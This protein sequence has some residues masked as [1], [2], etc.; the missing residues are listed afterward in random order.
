MLSSTLSLPLLL[1]AAVMLMECRDACMFFV[2]PLVFLPD[3]GVR[4]KGAY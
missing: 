1:M 4:G 2:L 3:Q